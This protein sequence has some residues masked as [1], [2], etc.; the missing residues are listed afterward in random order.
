MKVSHRQR[1]A[2]KF[3]ENLCS[4]RFE[5]DIENYHDVATFLDKYLS[6]A[7]QKMDEYRQRSL[8]YYVELYDLDCFF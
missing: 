2:V 8:E 3:C 1:N 4:T 5:G 7:K 6:K